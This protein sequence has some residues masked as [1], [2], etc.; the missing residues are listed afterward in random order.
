MQKENKGNGVKIGPGSCDPM[1]LDGWLK[2][3][4]SPI[5][6]TPSTLTDVS[7]KLFQD[8]DDETKAASWPVIPGCTTEEPTL[9]L[10]SGVEEWKKPDVGSGSCRLFGI[11][12]MKHPKTT[13]ISE[14]AIAAPAFSLYVPPIEGP[15]KATALV[16]ESDRQS[17]L[18]K[19]SREQ[20]QGLDSSLKEIQ[21]KHQGSTRSRTKVEKKHSQSYESSTK[22]TCHFHSENFCFYR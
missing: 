11:D 20:K 10:G 18:S 14:K 1:V 21:S 6:S 7:L 4:H 17:G 12:L 22:K 9:K 16:D 13:T 3:L 5:K 15:P 19:V 8:M 2:D